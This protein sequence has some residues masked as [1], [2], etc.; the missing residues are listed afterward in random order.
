M[1]NIPC[2]RVPVQHWDSTAYNGQRQSATTFSV[3]VFDKRV[4]SG[5]LCVE[6]STTAT[7]DKIAL[8]ASLEISCLPGSETEVPA[9]HLHFP[10]GERAMSVYA[11]DD[12]Y[13]IHPEQG[14]SVSEQ[15]CPATDGIGFVVEQAPTATEAFIGYAQV[16][17]L[18][19][20]VDF[21]MPVGASAQA[22]DAAMLAA[23]AQK[24]QIDYLAIGQS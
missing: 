3:A 20:E 18:R 11:S 1:N 15:E 10:S 8:H 24:M 23:L 5:M 13:L 19:I 9:L 17:G 7:P 16:D 22:K 14:V 21:E 4:L 2:F 12:K 6:A